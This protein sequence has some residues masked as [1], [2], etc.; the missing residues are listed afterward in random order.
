MD[1]VMAIPVQDWARLEQEPDVSILTKPDTRA[2]FIGMD[3][4]RDELLNS[5]VKGKN[6]FKDKRVREAV[7]RAVNNDVINKRI[8]RGHAQPLGTVIAT[9]INGY[10]DSFGKPYKTDVEKA[11]KLMAE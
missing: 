8:M 10:Q 9:S 2:M 4:H 3:Q 5:N 1:L 7:V 6:P 11:K